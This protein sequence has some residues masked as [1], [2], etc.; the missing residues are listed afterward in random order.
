ME[1][2]STRYLLWDV[3]RLFRQAFQTSPDMACLTLVQA[4]ALTCISYQQGIK[5]VDLAEL[6]EIT[7][8][9]LVR[10]IDSLVEEECVERRADTKDR[11]ACLIYLLPKGEEQ[12]KIVKN[13]SNQI[14]EHAFDGV[15]LSEQ[16]QFFDTLKA[17]HSN[18]SSISSQ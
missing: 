14:W 16:A 17:I 1:A 12:L 7:P 2:S 5:Q 13:I 15:S 8:M 6:L 3:T 4:K 18:L 10:I 11:R 9:T